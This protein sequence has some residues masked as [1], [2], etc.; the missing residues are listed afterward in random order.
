MGDA[1]GPVTMSPYESVFIGT[2]YFYIGKMELVDGNYALGCPSNLP[3]GAG[4]ESVASLRRAAGTAV[5][6]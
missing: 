2:V 3:A 4:R 6:A 1:H 5:P